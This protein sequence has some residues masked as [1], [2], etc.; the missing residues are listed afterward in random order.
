MKNARILRAEQSRAEQSRA[1]QSRAEQ[2]RA[3]QGRAALTNVNF[4]DNFI[5]VIIMP[6]IMWVYFLHENRRF[7]LSFV[8]TG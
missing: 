6:I 4:G 5:N 7:L 3:E 2:S 8:E 1:E